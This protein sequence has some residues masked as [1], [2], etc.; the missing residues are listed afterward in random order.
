M[1]GTGRVPTASSNFL[2]EFAMVLPLSVFQ[3][4]VISFLFHI[5]LRVTVLEEVLT[6]LLAP[7]MLS[8]VAVK[9]PL[10]ERFVPCQPPKV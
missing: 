2:V 3:T 7:R 4:M 9:V 6:S 1:V 10:V 5:A 8:L